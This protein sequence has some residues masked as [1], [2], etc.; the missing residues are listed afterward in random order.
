MMLLPRIA[1]FLPGANDL[2]PNPD[3]HK[4][5]PVAMGVTWALTAVCIII[6]AAR[7]YVRSRVTLSIGA[8]DW[9]M[10]AALIC[11]LGSQAACQKMYDNNL[12]NGEELVTYQQQAEI[13]K[14][15]WIQTLISL[16]CSILARISATIL[17]VRIFDTER[18][19]KRFLISF[20]VLM[21]VITVAAIVCFCLQCTPIAAFWNPEMV[22]TGE[23]TCW[24][25][26]IGQ[27]LA[28]L[29]QALY[30]FSDFTYVFFPVIIIWKLNMSLNRR[31][32]L[33]AI[34]MLSL[35]TMG[36][37]IVKTIASKILSVVGTEEVWWANP[38]ATVIS[39]GSEQCIVIIIGSIPPLLSVFKAAFAHV[40]G[41]VS[42]F[43]S[44]V[45]KGMTSKR[46]DKSR[47]FG[48]TFRKS[49]QPTVAPVNHEMDDLTGK[50]QDATF[51]SAWNDSD[52]DLQARLD[53]WR[54]DSFVVTY[55]KRGPQAS[56]GDSV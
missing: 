13:H 26:R 10:V 1:T 28:Y 30:S 47:S 27:Y 5:G 53:I 14:Y 39:S 8:D 23:A 24:D 35:I 32:S 52:P 18:W 22:V 43:G 54:T 2:V 42:S 31:M 45:S 51:D 34:M 40:R 38:S 21:S 50:D 17:L 46:R 56:S 16:P 36:A 11:R 33:I 41:A 44:Q 20:T 4:L 15:D 6:V 48:L 25:L 9:F 37:S 12:G 7:V 29:L 3:T 19:L 55:E 49:T